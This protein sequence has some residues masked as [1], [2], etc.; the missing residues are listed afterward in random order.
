[1][2]YRRYS[3]IFQNEML[4]IIACTIVNLIDPT[5]VNL[6]KKCKQSSGVSRASLGYPNIK[7]YREL[8]DCLTHLWREGKSNLTLGNSEIKSNEA[9]YAHMSRLNIFIRG[10]TRHASVCFIMGTRDSLLSTQTHVPTRG[11]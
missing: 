9:V 5:I 2:N 1:M 4:A 8:C 11:D 6:G 10:V 7:G 3:S